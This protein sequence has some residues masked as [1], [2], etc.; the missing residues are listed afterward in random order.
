MDT[1]PVV[2]RLRERS[3]SAGITDQELGAR[4]RVA[5]L[6]LRRFLDGELPMPAGVA[7]ALG[8]ALGFD[9]FVEAPPGLK[10]AF[11]VQGAPVLPPQDEALLHRAARRGAQAL[12]L[13]SILAAGGVLDPPLAPALRQQ[14][15]Q[16]VGNPGAQGRDRGARDRGEL[17][18]GGRPIEDL[19]GWMEDRGVVIAAWAFTDKHIDA[20]L[21]VAPRALPVVLLNE[22]SARVKQDRVRRAVLAHELGHLR[23]DAV[24]G[25]KR[26]TSTLSSAGAENT[27]EIEQR[28][29][30]YGPSFLAPEAWLSGGAPLERAQALVLEWGFSIEGAAWHALTA[31]GRNREPGAMDALRRELSG[32]LPAQLPPSGEAELP[33]PAEPSPL[34]RRLVGA[35]LAQGLIT[36][37]RAEELSGPV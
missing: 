16:L 26:P 5:P 20:A 15:V 30:A 37:R 10:V 18:P 11:R 9:P 19:C 21:V 24:Q 4:L 22:S 31:A 28:A 34:L 6:R 17:A 23:M 25:L 35:A 1:D 36:D 3:L 8:E 33:D 14:R 27:D 32:V 29:N 7:L 13:R 12:E 2:A